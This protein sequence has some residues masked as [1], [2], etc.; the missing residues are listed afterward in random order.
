MANIQVRNIATG[1]V[2]SIPEDQVP[3]M[4]AQ[5][6][7]VKAAPVAP[8][9]AATAN[10]PNNNPTSNT[11]TISVTKNGTTM[12]IDPANLSIW[13]SAG[14][15][16][17]GGTSA[18]V[19]PAT[20]TPAAPAT[21]LPFKT[22]LSS[23][24]QNS[25]ITLVAN[26]PDSST[27][28]ATDKANWNYATNNAPLPTKQ[29]GTTPDTTPPATP[30]PAA[31]SA[32]TGQEQVKY[33]YKPQDAIID[34]VVNLAGADATEEE[35]LAALDKLK[36]STIDP[37]FNQVIDQYKQ[38]VAQEVSRQAE[39]R[40]KQLD[41]ERFNALKNI[42]NTKKSLEASGMTFTGQ[43]IQQ[44]GAASA[45]PASPSAEVPKMTPEQMGLE[46][47]VNYANRV[48]AESSRQ[49]YARNQQDLA[50]AALARLGSANMGGLNFPTTS[51]TGQNI[52]G[53]IEYQR[54]NAILS[55]YG[56]L[57]NQKGALTDYQK[58]FY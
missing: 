34:E 38:Q 52:V 33:N 14:W 28:T 46:G 27:W 54:R 6:K 48:V 29:G 30:Q 53:G 40:V 49:A 22:G 11:G 57:A 50:A 24:Q 8:A 10:T 56:N 12:Q 58:L 7:V 19:A 42:E 31:S 17:T 44:L 23:V 9:P 13:T 37:Y 3:F 32:S 18:P 21:S 2:L 36:A 5:W 41:I 15:T 45:Y 4:S 43:G 51:P 47:D 16:Q 35:I 55:G 20:P 26:K 39:D 25:I 1:Q